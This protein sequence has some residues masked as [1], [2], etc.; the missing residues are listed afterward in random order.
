[1]PQSEFQYDRRVYTP[2][3][4]AVEVENGVLTHYVNKSDLPL[5]SKTLQDRVQQRLK[6]IERRHRG[7]SG[8][9]GDGDG[10]RG[11]GGYRGTGGDRGGFYPRGRGNGPRGGAR[12]N[13]RG[14]W[15]GDDN[16]G[17]WR[18]GRRGGWHGNR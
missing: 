17:D 15:R 18:G 3:K 8:I 10:W 9:G 13:W 14:S 6:D 1:M 11:R 16:G 7:E 12:G 2:P 4:D 5:T